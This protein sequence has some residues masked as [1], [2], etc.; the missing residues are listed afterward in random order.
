MH[1]PNEPKVH[2]DVPAQ[3][4]KPVQACVVPSLHEP[5]SDRAPSEPPPLLH[6]ATDARPSKANN[7]CDAT[8]TWKKAIEPS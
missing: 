7:P 8:R 1:A 2:V 5:P 6:E 3:P 4:P